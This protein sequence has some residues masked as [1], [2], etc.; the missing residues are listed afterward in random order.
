VVC[1][2]KYLHDLVT[3]RILACVFKERQVVFMLNKGIRK[4]IDDVACC[5]VGKEINGYA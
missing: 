2:V 5:C 3:L 4:Y 1:V